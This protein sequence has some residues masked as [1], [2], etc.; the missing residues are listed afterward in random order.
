MRWHVAALAVD[1]LA[2]R[3]AFLEK[4]A[5]LT[6]APILLAVFD[7]LSPLLPLVLLAAG[8]AQVRFLAILHRPRQPFLG[9]RLLVSH[10]CTRKQPFV[11]TLHSPT[12][13]RLV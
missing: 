6:L 11:A 3:P 10:G 1:V 7:V 9:L 13:Q 4:A 2:R 8:R 5:A 12:G